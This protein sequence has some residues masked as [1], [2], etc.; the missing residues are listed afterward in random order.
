MEIDLDINNYDFNDLIKLFNISKNLTEKE[1]K[2]AYRI[3]LKTHPDKSGLKK[4]YFL[5]FSKAFKLLKQVYDTCNKKESCVRKNIY[6]T[7]E[8]EDKIIK[9]ILRENKDNFNEKFNILFEKI[10]LED[11]EQDTGYGEWLKS[12]ENVINVNA[13]NVRNMGEEID[14]IKKTYRDIIKYDGIQDLVFNNSNYNLVRERKEEYSSDIFSKLKYED[15][16]KAHTETFIPVTEEDYHNR[17]QFSNTND[18]IMYRKQNETLLSEEDS[19]K[20]FRQK[21]IQEKEE[22][23]NNA[24]K[25]VKQMEKIKENNKLWMANFKLL[26]N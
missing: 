16:K 23:L 20:I 1:L 9:A 8:K 12:N 18:L 22:D 15:L 17:R 19:E 14:K 7:N 13:T 11:D 3:V 4:E 25:L 2:Y 5:F 10:K 26:K 24:Y 6:T 21:K